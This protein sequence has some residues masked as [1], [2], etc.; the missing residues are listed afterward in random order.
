MR[1]TEKQKEE[2]DV[3]R[4]VFKAYIRKNPKI[5]LV[6]SKIGYIYLSS[7]DYEEVFNSLL[8]EDGKMLCDLLL[9]E[10]AD[11]ILYKS[12]TGHTIITATLEERKQILREWSK[13]LNQLPVEYTEGVGEMLF[14]E[15]AMEQTEEM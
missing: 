4:E 1:Y 2:I 6:R 11:D 10:I 5:D 7:L 8:I 13:Y 3:V 9:S 15:N 14:P 12:E